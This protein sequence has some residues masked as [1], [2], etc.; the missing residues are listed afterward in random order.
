MQAEGIRKGDRLD[1]YDQF[2]K[3]C[4]GWTALARGTLDGPLVKVPVRY[5]DG[6]KAVLVW[7]YGEDVPITWGAGS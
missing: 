1:S 7:G 2:G 6:T 5:H 4:D 3:V